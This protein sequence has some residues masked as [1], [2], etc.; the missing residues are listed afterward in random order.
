MY[1]IETVNRNSTM[2]NTIKKKKITYNF[3]ENY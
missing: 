2:K 3:S 1:F